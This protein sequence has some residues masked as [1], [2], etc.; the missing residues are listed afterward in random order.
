LWPYLSQ[1]S[2]PSCSF[3]LGIAYLQGFIP[4]H[5]SPSERRS[6]VGYFW[7]AQSCLIR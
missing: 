6:W 1:S 7:L 5:N 4:D 2:R 3:S